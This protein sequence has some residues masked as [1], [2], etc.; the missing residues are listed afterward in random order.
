MAGH[1]KR[2]EGRAGHTGCS[3][4]AVGSYAAKNG[5]GGPADGGARIQLAYHFG[6]D[7]P[8]EHVNSFWKH[9]VYTDDCK[10]LY[11]R[12]IE[13]GGTSVLEPMELERWNCTIAMVKDPDGYDLEIVQNEA[14]SASE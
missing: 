11:K 13:A 9:Y 5:G 10:G 6:K 7:E 14:S 12:A 1:R 2:S 3:V 8:I 4:A